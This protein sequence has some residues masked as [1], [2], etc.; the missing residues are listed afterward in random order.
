[1]EQ[2][3]DPGNPY[4]AAW[5][6]IHDVDNDRDQKS[7]DM[8]ADRPL[9]PKATALYYA[10]SC[11]L[12][13]PAK[14]LISTHGEDV[15]AMCGYRQSPLREASWRG[16]L[17]AVSLLID[18]GA[19]VNMTSEGGCSPLCAAYEGRHLDIMQLLLENGSEMRCN[20]VG[21]LT[22]W[23]SG[24]G[25]AAVI[26]LFLQHNADPNATDGK[27]YTPLHSAS[28]M[29]HADVAQILLENGADINAVSDYGTPLYLA[30]DNGHLEM[31]RLLL[32]RGA[33]VNIRRRGY[34]TPF[35]VATKCGHADIMELLL[36]HG[37][38][39]E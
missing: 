21:L 6:W 17:D 27:N 8:P 9:C 31:V 3:F 39:K 18:H 2:L 4:L 34:Q 5:I 20:S 37:A 35:E 25:R 28:G 11:G 14:Y 38:N 22:H 32:E 19:D 1:M 15:N 24:Q 33:D 7:I 29:G 10:V 12:C 16:H 23:A 26:S 36:E 30:S 13:G